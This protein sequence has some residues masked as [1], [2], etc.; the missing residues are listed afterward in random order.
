MISLRSEAGEWHHCP[1]ME[2]RGIE[3]SSSGKEALG[4][5]EIARHTL[6]PIVV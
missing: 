1:G 4:S 2:E 5:T 6:K 3:I